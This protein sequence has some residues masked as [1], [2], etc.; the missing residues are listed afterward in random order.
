LI[1]KDKLINESVVSVKKVDG[2]QQ[3]SERSANKSLML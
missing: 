2:R 1:I 3:R